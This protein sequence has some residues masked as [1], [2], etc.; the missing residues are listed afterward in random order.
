[1]YRR[2]MERRLKVHRSVGTRI[3]AFPEG[4]KDEYL[5]QTRC[6]IDENTTRLLT[7]TE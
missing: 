6:W 4:T 5:L 1:M 2:V 3:E 7:R